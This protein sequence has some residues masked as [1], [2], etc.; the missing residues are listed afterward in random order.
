MRRFAHHHRNVR[1]RRSS[2]GVEVR[3]CPICRAED[4]VLIPAEFGSHRGDVALVHDREIASTQ[5]VLC[6]N[7]RTSLTVL[8]MVAERVG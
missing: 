1:A 4:A 6:R 8:P 3:D 2:V 7:C 5:Q